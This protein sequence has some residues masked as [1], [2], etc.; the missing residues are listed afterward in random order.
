MAEQ[1]IAFFPD[2]DSARSAAEALAGLGVPADAIRTDTDPS[3]ER[4]ARGLAFGVIV[5]AIVGAVV[6][7]PLAFIP[8]GEL[9][10]AWRLV[11]A[12]VVGM[13]A[14]GAAGFVIGGGFT[15]GD[16]TDQL[17]EHP[18]VVLAVDDSR[19]DVVRALEQHRATLVE[20]AVVA[21]G[22]RQGGGV[23]HDL[24]H[25]LREGTGS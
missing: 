19:P 14:G 25:K 3:F 23:A 15:A 18:G 11:G 22:R 7:V 20:R 16:E 1:L 8:L 4:V 24:G 2:D 6:C 13:V 17:G 5:G 21:E 10:F 12:L 9:A